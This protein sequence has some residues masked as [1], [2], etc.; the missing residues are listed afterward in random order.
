M[1]L[2]VWAAPRCC[3]GP[4]GSDAAGVGLF[5]VYEQACCSRSWPLALPLPLSMLRARIEVAPLSGVPVVDPVSCLSCSPPPL[6]LLLPPPPPVSLCLLLLPL[7]LS[8]VRVRD[9]GG[10]SAAAAA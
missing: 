1:L 7:P 4:E 9:S 3:V 6:L 2:H 5:F 8:A 10:G